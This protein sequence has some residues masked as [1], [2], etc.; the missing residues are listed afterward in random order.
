MKEEEKE[1]EEEAEMFEISD[2]SS[3]TLSNLLWILAVSCRTA[4]L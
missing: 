3:P 2:A 4:V 1:E